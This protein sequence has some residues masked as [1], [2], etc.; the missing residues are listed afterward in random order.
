MDHAQRGPYK[1]DQQR[2]FLST[3]QV[4]QVILLHTVELENRKDMAYDNFH[5]DSLYGKI[6][7]QK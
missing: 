6:L 1:N 4:I 7:T 3:D 2:I 5:G